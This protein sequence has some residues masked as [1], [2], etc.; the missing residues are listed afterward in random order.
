MK[1]AFREFFLLKIGGDKNR[2][3]SDHLQIFEEISLRSVQCLIISDGNE[4]H[5]TIYQF[6]FISAFYFIVIILYA[7]R[8]VDII[9]DCIG[10]SYWQKNAK[11][12]AV[13]GTWVLYG[14]MGGRAVDGPL[15]GDILRKRINLKGSTLRSRSD[16]VSL[17]QEAVIVIWVNFIF[18]EARLF[19]QRLQFC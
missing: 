13:D 2:R 10:Q 19:C 9:L 6:Y 12:I 8:G 7:G 3:Q 18:L 17:G 14:L 4:S 11:S 16:E 1:C 5:K 15:L